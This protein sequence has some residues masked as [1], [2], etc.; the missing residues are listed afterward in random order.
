MK[1][2]IDVEKLGIP[3]SDTGNKKPNQ[4]RDFDELR[5]LKIGGFF[6][7][8]LPIGVRI[9]GTDAQTAANYLALFFI[10]N[11]LSRSYLV[12]RVTERHETA[13]N[14][15][16]AVTVMLNKVPSGTDPASGTSILTAGLSLKSTANT[17]QDGSLTS[18]IADKRLG[19]G[20][21]LAL[22]T[23]GTLTNVVGVTV[24]VLLKA[25]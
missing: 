18:V 13:G 25:I 21:G 24:S 12:V 10:N 9:P 16:S 19:P 2:E 14:D 8:T 7:V 23:S 11:H 20:D 6:G 3:E 22:E 1:E 5:I 4:S 15:A 17:N